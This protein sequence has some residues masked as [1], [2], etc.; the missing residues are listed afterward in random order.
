[1]NVDPT[2]FLGASGFVMESGV[3]I[4][5]PMPIDFKKSHESANTNF[6]KD[7]NE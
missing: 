1:M 7:P 2:I 4:I 5:P 3:V 6:E